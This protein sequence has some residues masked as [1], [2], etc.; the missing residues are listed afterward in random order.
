[1]S[2]NTVKP[3]QLKIMFTIFVNN[4]FVKLDILRYQQK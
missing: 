1:M 4:V 3:L 2:I